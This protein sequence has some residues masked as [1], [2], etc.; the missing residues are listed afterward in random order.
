M[1]DPGQILILALAFMTLTFLTGGFLYWAV[2]TV[3][4]PPSDEDE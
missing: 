3:R 1:T 2:T 4:R